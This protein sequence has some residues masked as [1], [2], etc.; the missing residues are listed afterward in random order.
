MRWVILIIASAIMYF[1]LAFLFFSPPPFTAITLSY[2]GGAALALFSLL[3]V[4]CWWR[5][6]ASGTGRPAIQV[7]LGCAAREAT[8]ALLGSLLI[9]VLVIA[10]SALFPP[11]WGVRGV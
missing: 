1:G 9:M 8:L 3:M 7:V 5:C 10:M 4:S 11:P 6:R 2:G